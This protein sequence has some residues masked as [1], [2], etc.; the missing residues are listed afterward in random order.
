MTDVEVMARL[1]DALGVRT[2]DLVFVGGWAHRILA[3][4]RLAVSSFAPL[5]TQDVDILVTRQTP[6]ATNILGLLEGAGFVPK[7]K[8]GDEQPPVAEYV[9]PSNP[10]TPIEFL[11]DAPP[12]RRPSV[13]A[14]VSGI[15]AQALTG[16]GLLQLDTWNVEL[17]R[18][19][20]FPVAKACLVRV[21]N[22]VAF[23]T[24]KVLLARRRS[25]RSEREKDILYAYDTLTLF[26][27]AKSEL[28]RHGEIVVGA[29]SR[30]ERATLVET[31]GALDTGSDL[32][33]GAA[34]IATSSGRPRPPGGPPSSVDH[35]DRGRVTA[36]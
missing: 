30:R 27:G 22:P 19:N 9:H 23:S 36:K 17:N 1:L 25:S 6:Q 12:S 2:A 29:L 26:A 24:H 13:T 35:A 11:I 14:L 16:L 28:L 33:R 31:L 18:G 32:A 5:A 3:L 20:G 10:S 7:F 34:Q 4:H 21:P 15:S 8:M